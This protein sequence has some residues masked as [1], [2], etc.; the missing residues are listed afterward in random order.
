MKKLLDVLFEG[1]EFK[2]IKDIPDEFVNDE[3]CEQFKNNSSNEIYSDLTGK[4]VYNE[5]DKFV[6]IRTIP[7]S[8]MLLRRSDNLILNAGAYKVTLFLRNNN[9]KNT[10]I[11]ISDN[12]EHE[13]SIGD[14]NGTKYVFEVLAKNDIREK[15]AN[16]WLKEILRDDE[17]ILTS[18]FTGKKYSFLEKISR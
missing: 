9:N 5:K 4:I 11:K 16:L 15:Y 13:Y 10:I 17:K 3:M 12:R 18:L 2:K 6:V 1:N 14:K 7:R 8:V